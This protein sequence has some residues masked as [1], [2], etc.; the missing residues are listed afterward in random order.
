MAYVVAGVCSATVARSAETSTRTTK[1]L[2]LPEL[3]FSELAWPG[4]RKA[5]RSSA[6]AGHDRPGGRVTRAGQR[7][8]LRAVA[9]RAGV[10]IGTASAVFADKA[11][12]SGSVRAAVRAAAEELDYQPRARRAV[13]PQAASPVTTIGFVS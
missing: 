6:G 10:S 9:E 1:T 2:R 11:W 4:D 12:V 8:T 7:T 3:N 13:A 5:C